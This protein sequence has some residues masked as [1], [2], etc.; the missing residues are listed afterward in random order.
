MSCASS[1]SIILDRM[2]LISGPSTSTD[3]SVLY[4]EL[5]GEVAAFFHSRDRQLL[6]DLVSAVKRSQKRIKDAE[7][8]APAHAD[9]G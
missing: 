4:V 3:G 2:E 5:E 9:A 8:K 1:F 6:L 7:Q